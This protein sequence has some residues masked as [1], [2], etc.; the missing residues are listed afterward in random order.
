M[1]IP[2]YF[3][4]G[5]IG[6]GYIIPQ[7]PDISEQDLYTSILDAADKGNEIAQAILDMLPISHYESVYTSSKYG[8]A[9]RQNRLTRIILTP[10]HYPPSFKGRC[11]P[12]LQRQAKAGHY[13]AMRLI[14]KLARHRLLDPDFEIIDTGR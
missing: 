14:S 5:I 10:S 6:S 9:L 3:M 4:G 13:T 11:M 8:V 12:E 2:K 1:V 7:G